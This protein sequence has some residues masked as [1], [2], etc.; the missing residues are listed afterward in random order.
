MSCT[1]SPLTT[2]SNGCILTLSRLRT[3]DNFYM[4]EKPKRNQRIVEMRNKGLTFTAIA[5]KLKISKQRARLIYLN[6]VKQKRVRQRKNKKSCIFGS[7]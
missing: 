5:K 1:L 2:L 3:V 6:Q 4:H 7:G